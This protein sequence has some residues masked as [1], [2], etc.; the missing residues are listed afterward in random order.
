MNKDHI[1]FPQRGKMII[2][3]ENS[4]NRFSSR[5]DTVKEIISESEDGSNDTLHG[6]VQ[7]NKAICF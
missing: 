6:T 2:E 3:I 5:I 1:K 4:S 7:R